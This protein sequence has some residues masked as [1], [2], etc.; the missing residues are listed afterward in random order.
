MWT[1]EYCNYSYFGELGDIRRVSI[2]S[3]F[4]GN[5]VSLTCFMRNGNIGEQTEDFHFADLQLAKN[6][7]QDWTTRGIV[8][9]IG[10]ICSIN[11]E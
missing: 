1:R 2:R 9:N 7:G 6:A 3:G 5:T 11:L 4:I 8:P 10:I